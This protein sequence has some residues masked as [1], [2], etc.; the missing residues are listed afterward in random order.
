[1][2]LLGMGSMDRIWIRGKDAA[3][4]D[5]ERIVEV[6]YAGQQCE[7]NGSILQSLGIPTSRVN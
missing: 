5:L 7:L 1:M 6:E 2:Y 4:A 3:N